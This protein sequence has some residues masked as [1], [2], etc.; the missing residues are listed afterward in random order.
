MCSTRRLHG[1]IYTVL[2]VFAV[3]LACIASVPF[4]VRAERNIGPREW[5]PIFRASRMR[6]LLLAARDFVWLERERL[7][8]RQQFVYNHNLILVCNPKQSIVTFRLMIDLWLAC[9]VIKI[10]LVLPY[11]KHLINRTKSVCMGEP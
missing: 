4:P 6:K 10:V 8:R 5:G 2:V 11:N 9:C 7:L 3:R 1:A